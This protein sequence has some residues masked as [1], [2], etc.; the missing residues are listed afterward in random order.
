MRSIFDHR[1]E[2]LSRVD[3]WFRL[4]PLS[5]EDT[6]ELIRFR[7]AVA[8]RKDPLLTQTAFLE[9]W[10]E[11]RGI[12]REIVTLCSKVI[13]AMGTMGRQVADNSV[14]QAAMKDSLPPR[15]DLDLEG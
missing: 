12:P 15:G 5:L 4:N 8:G 3:S 7:C 10:R 9:V 6:L 2:V 11:T 14:V 13:D 1:P